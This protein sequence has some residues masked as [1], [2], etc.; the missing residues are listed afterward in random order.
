M[1]AE[2]M[3]E[4]DRCHLKLPVSEWC[5]RL[6]CTA[7]KLRSFLDDGV[8][9]LSIRF[10][11]DAETLVIEIPNLLKKKDEY[12][13]KI[14]TKSK[15]ESGQTP[16]K[17]EERRE[18]KK[19]TLTT[20]VVSEE[21]RGGLRSS[22]VRSN[23]PKAEIAQNASDPFDVAAGD[24]LDRVKDFV[25]LN[26]NDKAGIM[27]DLSLHGQPELLDWIIDSLQTAKTDGRLNVTEHGITNPVGW[28]RK[29]IQ[30]ETNTERRAR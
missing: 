6:D 14:G 22:P 26:E 25:N 20:G 8:N 11:E 28:I 9:A 3:D 18:K 23:F 5:R 16:P 15:K 27:F 2:K 13:N 30:D 19:E 12:S 1:V 29:Q 10:E 24:F 21:R 7:K 4:T 17:S